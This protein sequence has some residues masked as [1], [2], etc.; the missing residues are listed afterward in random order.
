MKNVIVKE[1][2]IKGKDWEN[3]LDEAFKKDVKN[4]NLDGFR[5]GSVPKDIFLKKF[6]VESLY[7]DAM[8][9]GLQT[10]YAK[11]MDDNKD[12]I[13]VVEPKID[14]KD[15]NET[16]IVYEF[17]IITHPEVKLGAY[18]NLGI[19]KEEVKVS[20]KE[21]TEEIDKLRSRFAEV[22]VKD[23]GEV[24]NGNTAVIDFSGMVDGK[25]LDGGSGENYPLEIGSHTFIPGFEEGLIGMKKGESK[26]LKLTF[27][28]NYTEAL[29]NKEVTF[30][31]TIH[32]I[33]ERVLPELNNEF[34]EDLGYKDIKSEAEF[35]D[36][37]E[38]EVK[39]RKNNQVED[40]YVDECLD[41]AAKNM[42]V[43]INPEII[44]EEV[45]RMMHQFEDQIK[46]QG[47][48]LEQYLQFSG[49]TM[50]AFEK[51]MEP[52]ATKRVQARYLLEA[53]ADKENIKF[54]DKEANAEA[55]KMAKNYGITKEELIQEF[56]G[57][58]V[59]KYD[60]RMRKAI[61]IVKGE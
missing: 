23:N 7:R 4:V 45:H 30:K 15:I 12:L 9:I 37:V 43:E 31:V 24:A 33:K 47:L 29:K 59:V 48:N 39:A 1:F 19:K 61:E 42:T 14:V 16:H 52:E 36:K 58:D 51:Q 57:L 50:D 55:E 22:V 26:E 21:L 46:M 17:T 20:A 49:M 8:D 10:A 13:P 38:A 60:M 34:Y 35:K 2:E 11:V 54:E 5:K 25:P 40:K 28:E 41:K 3:I 56:G 18:K 44:E 6:G 53:I 32:E 27:P